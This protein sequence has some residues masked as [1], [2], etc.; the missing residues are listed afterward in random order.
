VSEH[1]SRRAEPKEAAMPATRRTP[2]D[3]P[4]ENMRRAQ[5]TLR[6][7]RGR[8]RLK[9]PLEAG[10]TGLLLA[11]AIAASEPEAAIAEA[12][13]ALTSFEVLGAARNADAAAAFPAHARRQGGSLG[14]AGRRRS[15][16]AGARAAGPPGRR[17]L[18]PADGQAPVRHPQDGR[19]SRGQRALQARVEGACGG[20]GICRP[21]PRTLTGCARR[22]LVA[23]FHRQI[24]DLAHA[25]ASATCHVGG[26]N[27][28]AT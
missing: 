10:G 7:R 24:G 19:E 1:V 12:R 11:R 28:E 13:A 15:D 17:P 16:Q 26:H 3:R 9:L 6:P 2:P 5:P 27:K 8:A 18:E 21:P 22:P 23:N 20:C 14:P 25:R 4:Q